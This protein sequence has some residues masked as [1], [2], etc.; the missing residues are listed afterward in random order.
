MKQRLITGS[1]YVA[2]LVGF[3]LLKI[4]LPEPWNALSF[5]LLLYA[6]SVIGAFEMIRALGDKLTG[7]QQ[8]ICF[9]FAALFIPA[10]EISMYCFDY[11]RLSVMAVSS[12]IVAVVLCSL[13]VVQYEKT[14]LESVGCSLLACV[15]PTV[16]IG[17]L[18]LSNHLKTYSDLALLFIFV[19]SPCAD[20]FAYLFGVA[21]GKK[22]PKKMS[23]HISPKKTVVGCIGGVIGGMLGALVLFFLYNL[24]YGGVMPYET[25]AVYLLVGA[26]ESLFTEFG[27]LVESAIKRKV[28]IKDMG[29]IMPGHGGVLD[30]IDGTMYAAVLVYSVFFILLGINVL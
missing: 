27:D 14:S 10:Y 8:I 9:L 2:I 28:D 16:L 18:V 17:I 12:F 3:F 25:L 30:R 6:F 5:D 23:P 7:A 13:L 4:Y 1:C 22:F 21:F 29:K 24:A 26:G 19:V 20:S 15:Y 11:D